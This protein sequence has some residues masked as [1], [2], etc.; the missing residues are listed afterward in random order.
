MNLPF[1]KPNELKVIQYLTER[2]TAMLAQ[3]DSV[4]ND[5]K[6]EQ[7]SSSGEGPEAMMARLRLQERAAL[8]G[9]LQRLKSELISLQVIGN[10]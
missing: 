9:T 3:M 7:I 4:S 5:D 1:S 8:K 6:D 10:S 2:C